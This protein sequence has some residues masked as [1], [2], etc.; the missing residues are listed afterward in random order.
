M[1]EI[2]PGLPTVLVDWSPRN[3]WNYLYLKVKHCQVL[4]HKHTKLKNHRIFGGKLACRDLDCLFSFT[5]EHIILLVG[6]HIVD[7]KAGRGA[8]I[9]WIPVGT[10][11]YKISFYILFIRKT[12]PVWLE[13]RIV[14]T[15][16]SLFVGTD[17]KFWDWGV[18]SCFRRF[19][20][21]KLLSSQ[22]KYCITL[23][24]NMWG[25]DG[26]IINPCLLS[27]CLIILFQSLL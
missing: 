27:S 4:S 14:R 12:L 6:G 8:W 22:G 24:N 5:R 17:G 7:G 9:S 25:I 16:W 23:K 2:W 1:R 20:N 11:G 15:L 21:T 10:A 18:K 3:V 26:N 19:S 13:P